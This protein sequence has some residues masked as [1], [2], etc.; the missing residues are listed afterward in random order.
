M[1][2]EV[3]VTNVCAVAGC[4]SRVEELVLPAN[5]AAPATDTGPALAIRRTRAGRA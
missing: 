2:L 4:G 3:L 5:A 1:S